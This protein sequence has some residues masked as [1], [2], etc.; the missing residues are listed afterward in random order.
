MK[1]NTKTKL[2]RHDLISVYTELGAEAFYNALDDIIDQEIKEKVKTPTFGENFWKFLSNVWRSI[3]IR[4]DEY[5]LIASVIAFFY[6]AYWFC[7][8]DMRGK[9]QDEKLCKTGDKVG[10]LK[11]WTDNTY[12]KDNTNYETERATF[13]KSVYHLATNKELLT[14][15]E[16]EKNK[17]K[18]YNNSLR[19]LN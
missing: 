16:Y 19:S 17:C 5:Y 4:L 14:D 13:L 3:E 2:T 15:T 7:T 9:A 11:A 1:A 6:F 8:I 18:P 12:F 10:C